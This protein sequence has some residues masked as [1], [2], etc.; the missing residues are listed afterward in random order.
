M[1]VWI[2][3]QPRS[4]STAFTSLI[5][6]RLNRINK[7]V[8]YPEDLDVVKNIPN[9]EDYVF[10]THCYDFMEIMNLFDK[11]V[12]LIQCL[13]QDKIECCISSLIAKYRTNYGANV[14]NI[15]RR[16]DP[17]EYENFTAGIEPM[18]FPKKEVYNYLQYHTKVN[19]YWQEHAAPY[20]NCTIFYEDLCTDN[21]VDVPM[22]G[23]T[24]LSI[25]TDE[26][27]TVKLPDY[28]KQ[29]CLNYDM[30]AGWITEYCLKNE[31]RPGGGMV[32]TQ[33]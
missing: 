11:P 10:S 12:V 1:I 20:Q 29:V 4:G 26:S 25:A 23:L 8:R 2:F 14:W 31:L 6:N 33:R 19:Q 15:L 9:P 30:V 22:L 17:S 5:A 27:L 18:I 24:S 7:F 32:D 16:S 3:R 28:K 21:G 13:R